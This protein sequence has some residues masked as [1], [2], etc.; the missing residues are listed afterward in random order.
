MFIAK[1]LTTEL[2]AVM[3]PNLWKPLT[4]MWMM[5]PQ[6]VNEWNNPV[7]IKWRELEQQS[8]LY[9]YSHSTFKS[10]LYFIVLYFVSADT[11]RTKWNLLPSAE[12]SE[13]VKSRNE[14]FDY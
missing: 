5:E 14:F 12:I 1:M 11:N 4:K 7:F 9:I 3:G 13:N 2:G 8:I 6:R 10:L